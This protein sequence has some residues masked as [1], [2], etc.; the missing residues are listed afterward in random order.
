MPERLLIHWNSDGL[1]GCDA[2]LGRGKARI[3]QCFSFPLPNPE[4]GEQTVAAEKL[5]A[6]TQEFGSWIRDRVREAGLK[7]REVSVLLPRNDCFVRRVELPPT[8]LD[9]LP[10]LVRMQAAAICSTPVEDLAIDFLP[11]PDTAGA[12]SQAVLLITI[13]KSRIAFLRNALQVAD[14][15]LV[16]VG[17]TP[18]ASAEL[19]LRDDA[20][21][22][23][24]QEGPAIVITGGASAIEISAVFRNHVLNAHTTDIAG[25]T[26]D[27]ARK[28]VLA[29]LSRFIVPLQHQY[30]GSSISACRILR[31]LPS[32]ID[33][34]NA[35]EQR[36]AWPVEEV[37]A[38]ELSAEAMTFAS[39]TSS[40]CCLPALGEVLRTGHAN[41]PAVDFINP[42]RSVVKKDY[43]RHRMVAAAVAGLLVILAGYGYFK[44]EQSRLQSQIDNRRTEEG[45]LDAALQKGKPQLEDAA[46]I[47]RWQ[48]RAVDWIDR[49][50]H[51]GE[52]LPER[53]RLYL[54]DL[55]VN[56]VTG[57]ALFVVQANGLAADRRDIEQLYQELSDRAY[58]VYPQ[59]IV[60]NEDDKK[61]PYQFELRF[62]ILRE[63]L[64]ETETPESAGK[65]ASATSPAS[66]VSSLNS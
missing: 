52:T 16:S 36:F 39:G 25:L 62:D 64:L 7:S 2:Q 43:S 45:L 3:S 41:V 49:L 13:A 46:A 42:R 1:E 58:R 32:G 34:L 21:R 56:P 54:T 65:P 20:F 47:E 59:S 18:P 51:L 57:D 9:E 17:I 30:P 8:P 11:L 4:S 37:D 48:G 14:L 61:Y 33:L 53:E 31:P 50:Q 35:V 60:T 23:A 19:A 27:E 24:Q 22:A 26:A 40:S 66:N 55:R 28:H 15:E 63:T 6:S 10:D 12:T 29:D 38:C 44:V 5:R